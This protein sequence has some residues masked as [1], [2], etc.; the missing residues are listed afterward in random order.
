MEYSP[1]F[2]TKK[3]SKKQFETSNE[4]AVPNGLMRKS[5]KSKKREEKKQ[6]ESFDA[7]LK[8]HINYQ[9]KTQAELSF[10]AAGRQ[11]QKL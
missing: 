6:S 2:L 1:A 7:V 11:R 5:L 3:N 10:D 9:P 4:N 8:S